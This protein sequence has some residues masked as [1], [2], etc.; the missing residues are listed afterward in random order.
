MTMKQNGKQKTSKNAAARQAAAAKTNSATQAQPD[1]WSKARGRN[2][3]LNPLLSRTWLVIGALEIVFMALCARVGWYTIANIAVVGTA[4]YTVH[5]AKVRRA[6]F[7]SNRDVLKKMTKKEKRVFLEVDDR[8]VKNIAATSR[9][10]PF[11]IFGCLL[12]NAYT[13]YYNVSE[14]MTTAMVAN[15][16]DAANLW[17]LIAGLVFG[18]IFYFAF[19]AKMN[20]MMKLDELD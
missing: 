7:M 12:L 15:I 20:D 18:V 14:G 6:R 10:M 16:P 9:M 17:L 8:E 3:P 2:N 5:L 4:I 19:C 1:K 13:Y 11:L